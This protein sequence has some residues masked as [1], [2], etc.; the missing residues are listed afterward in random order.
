MHSFSASFISC[1]TWIDEIIDPV[2][3]MHKEY[4]E[5]PDFWSYRVIP[6]NLSL[7]HHAVRVYV[8]E[9]RPLRQQEH[10]PPRPEPLL[11]VQ[12]PLLQD[13]VA[14]HEAVE[15]IAADLLVQPPSTLLFAQVHNV[16][17]PVRGARM[18][19]R[20][21]GRGKSRGFDGRRLT[22]IRRSTFVISLS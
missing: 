2:G 7:E 20:R 21:R 8:V 16:A 17:E 10:S 13:E 18:D 11:L 14:L 1:C 5:I 15:A 9:V 12:D 4:F 3:R 19:R 22:L 6:W